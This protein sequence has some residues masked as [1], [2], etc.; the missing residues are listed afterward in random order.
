MFVCDKESITIR[1]VPKYT[2]KQSNTYT[3]AFFRTA[4]QC[5]VPSI[6]YHSPLLTAP[7]VAPTNW[8]HYY[9]DF[10]STPMTATNSVTLVVAVRQWPTCPSI[11]PVVLPQPI[12]EWKTVPKHWFC[13]CCCYYCC[14]YCYC[15][16]PVATLVPPRRHYCCCCC[17]WPRPP[18][19][20][21]PFRD[22]IPWE[23]A[24]TGALLLSH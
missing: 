12:A 10:D 4:L 23:V 22:D 8:W 15:A 18:P 24:T 20:A 16:V 21:F 5:T 3:H 2:P 11:H 13:C 7:I 6:T 17:P 19:I 9:Y 1:M 14:C